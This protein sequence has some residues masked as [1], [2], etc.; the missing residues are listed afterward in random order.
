MIVIGLLFLPVLLTFI[1]VLF[2]DVVADFV[3]G[4]LRIFR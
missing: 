3:V 2:F 1:M 4:V